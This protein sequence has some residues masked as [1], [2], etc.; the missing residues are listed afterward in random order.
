MLAPA[1]VHRIYAIITCIGAEGFAACVWFSS[2]PLPGRTI[3]LGALLVRSP[4]LTVLSLAQR[5]L[6]ERV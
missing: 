4:V 6:L 3:L 5:G 2:L 1:A